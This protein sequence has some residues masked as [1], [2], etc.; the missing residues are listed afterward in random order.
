MNTVRN[1]AEATA[2][3]YAVLREEAVEHDLGKVLDSVTE[4]ADQ[5]RTSILNHKIPARTRIALVEQLTDLGFRAQATVQS[6]HAKTAQLTVAWD[7]EP[8]P[9]ITSRG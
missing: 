4:A 6:L 3:T 5:G 9:C 1:A 7:A 2:R 8:E